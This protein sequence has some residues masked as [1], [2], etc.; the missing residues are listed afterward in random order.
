MQPIG[1]NPSYDLNN[2]GKWAS[3]DVRRVWKNCEIEEISF[4]RLAKE[5]WQLQEDT[6]DRQGRQSSHVSTGCGSVS[7]YR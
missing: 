5:G 2:L 1:D 7:V 3:N 6:L 4:S